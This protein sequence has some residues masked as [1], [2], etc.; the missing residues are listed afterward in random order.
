MKHSNVLRAGLCAAVFSLATLPALA[1]KDV[2]VATVNGEKIMRSDVEAAHGKLPAQYQQV[3][4]DQ[5]FPALLDNVINT[6]LAAAAAREAMLNETK[7]Y[8][9]EL[10]SFQE[11]LLGAMMMQQAVEKGITDARIKSRYDDMI[12]QMGDQSEVHARHIL[13]KT[14]DEAVAVIKDI[15][16]GADFAETA[17]KKSTGPSGPNGGDLGFFGKGQMVPEFEKAAFALKRGEVT[18]K[19]V[20]TQFGWHVI[21]VEDKRSQQPPAY[22]EMEGQI[23]QQMMQEAGAVY[24]EELR[25]GAKIQRFNL[26]GTPVK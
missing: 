21:K 11:R 26:D 17:K 4:F 6:K 16:G 24:A 25:K 9:D 22:K 5:I 18:K 8:K 23:R 3:P 15:A 14:E 13:V 7:E 2:I 10:V 20:K 12:K 1:D 19:P